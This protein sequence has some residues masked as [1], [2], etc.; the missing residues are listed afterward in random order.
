MV[1]DRRVG[2]Q[3]GDRQLVDVEPEDA[4][5]QQAA[6][7]VVKPEALAQIA[8]HLGCFHS[9]TSTVTIA[10]R[11]TCEATLRQ[12]PTPAREQPLART[13]LCRRRSGLGRDGFVPTTRFSSCGGIARSAP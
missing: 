3:P 13:D 5:P 4:C 11:T 2:C 12:P 10:A 1:E 6:C 9:V 7:D 8:Q